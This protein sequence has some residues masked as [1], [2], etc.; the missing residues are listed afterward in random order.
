MIV[1]VCYL[2]KPEFGMQ[3]SFSRPKSAR[4]YVA[5]ATKPVL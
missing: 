1:V 2:M 3:S 4:W 5:A